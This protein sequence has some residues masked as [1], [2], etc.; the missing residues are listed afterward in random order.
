MA[1][2][3]DG[4]PRHADAGADIVLLDIPL[5]FETGAEEGMDAVVVAS[6]PAAIQRER[7]L[8]RPGMTEEKFDSP[9]GP[10]DA[11][12]GKACQGAFRG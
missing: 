11:G 1:G 9:A 7:V 3:R 6:A 4:I 10:P 12:C 2:D 5:L 8:A